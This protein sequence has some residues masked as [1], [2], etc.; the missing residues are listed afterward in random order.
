MSGEKPS[1]EA[2]ARMHANRA[3]DLANRI[4]LL[5]AEARD[6]AQAVFAHVPA[7]QFDGYMISHQAGA[8]IRMLGDC[9]SVALDV[10]RRLQ[11]EAEKSALNPVKAQLEPPAKVNP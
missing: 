5:E 1:A 2:L 11:R 9:A 3:L 8:L 6:Y 10:H 4:R 7:D